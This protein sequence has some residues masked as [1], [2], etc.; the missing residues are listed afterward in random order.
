MSCTREAPTLGSARSM[1]ASDD[2][3]SGHS[4]IDWESRRGSFRSDRSG[5]ERRG[6]QARVDLS[7]AIVAPNAVP[8]DQVESTLYQHQVP[9]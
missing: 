9:R 6:Q 2:P 3:T 8:R 4:A 5:L 7:R 1:E